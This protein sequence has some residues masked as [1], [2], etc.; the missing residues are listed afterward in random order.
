MANQ[1]HLNLLLQGQDIWNQW[2][3]ENPHVTP[4]LS[5]ADLSRIDLP[6]RTLVDRWN[7]KYVNLTRSN[8]RQA[9]LEAVD[10]SHASL[11][12]AFLAD[13]YI[14]QAILFQAD[15]SYATLDGANLQSADLRQANLQ[16]ADL[17]ETRLPYADLSDANLQDANLEH[18][19]I[20]GTKLCNTNLE[21]S[22]I[23][24]ISV[25]DTELSGA[26]QSNLV[27]T[28]YDQPLITVDNLEVAQLIYLLLN[29][30]KI[31]DVIDSISSKT[32]LILGRFTLKRRLV[33][34]AIRNSLRKHNLIPILF[35]FS[36]PNSR[37]LTETVSTLAHISRFVVA[38]LTDAKSVPHE[39][40]RIIPHLPS[41]PI[42]TL[43]ESSEPEYGMIK[44]F[45]DYPWVTSPFC[46]KSVNELIRFLE[47]E[48][49]M[50]MG[51]FTC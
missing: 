33:L 2:R 49:L 8:L 5:F 26:N 12:E 19:N 16:N 1:E 38:D 35:D 36:R 17:L 47:N 42:Q 7:L 11:G 46:Y 31:R 45:L 32:V 44:D 29:N 51:G 14:G 28:K 23:Y 43:I 40:Q 15:L 22:R 10:L 13:A 37:N 6:S 34:E 24:G 27:V 18:A 30:S 41:V 50:A 21:G 3:I 4:D 48:V 39:L 9:N 20:I 25:W